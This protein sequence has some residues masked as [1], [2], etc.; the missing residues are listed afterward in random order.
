[1][2]QKTDQNSV[3]LGRKSSYSESITHNGHVY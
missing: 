1:L 3:F 2:R